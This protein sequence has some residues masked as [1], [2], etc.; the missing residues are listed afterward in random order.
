MEKERDGQ[1]EL[2]F[3]CPDTQPPHWKKPENDLLLDVQY[4]V[5]DRR[6]LNMNVNLNANVYMNCDYY[7]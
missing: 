4:F 2:L 7:Y 3:K 6:T 5:H 1:R